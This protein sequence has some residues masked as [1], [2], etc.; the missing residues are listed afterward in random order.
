MN[1]SPEQQRLLGA[2]GYELMVRVAPGAPATARAESGPAAPTGPAAASPTGSAAAPAEGWAAL[3]RAVRLAAGERDLEGLVP[4]YDRLR[5][6][7]A[8]KRALWP[9]LRALRRSH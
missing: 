5:R 8:L 6:E 7:P 3:R 9:R 4:D 2:M 1:W